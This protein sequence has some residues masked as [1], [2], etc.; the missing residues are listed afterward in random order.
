MMEIEIHTEFI[1]LQQVLKLA[2]YLDQGSDI[3]AYLAEE[4]VMVNGEIVT[5]R[6][7]KIYPG[8]IIECKGFEKL[9]VISEN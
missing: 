6:G 5:Q 7:K 8:D 4:E 9:K 2:G 1:K 3:K